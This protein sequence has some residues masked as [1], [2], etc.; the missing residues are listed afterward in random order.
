MHIHLADI[1]SAFCKKI[2]EE[3][4]KRIYKDLISFLVNNLGKNTSGKWR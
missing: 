2:E 1:Y 3:T 4:N